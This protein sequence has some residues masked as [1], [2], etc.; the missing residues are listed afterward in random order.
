MNIKGAIFDFDGTLGDS[1]GYWE[2]QYNEISRIYCGGKKLILT[3]ED[4]KKFRTSLITDSMKLLHKNYNIAK[5]AEE[6]INYVNDSIKRFYLTEVKTKPGVVE[7]LEYLKNKNVKMCI[8]SATAEAEL[9]IAV[10]CC[11][12]ERYF[13]KLFSCSTLGFG[14]EKPDIF[15][16]ALD[17]LGTDINETLVIEDS[18]LA[19]E[20]AKKAGFKTVG[21]FDKN[22]PYTENQLA[23]YSDILV[24]EN[25]TLADLIEE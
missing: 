10:K 21:I 23:E 8:A 5:S 24:G 16:M 12:L 9:E 19:L 20:T 14:K 15:L 6:L 18:L 3:P 13:D 1:L 25:Q 4:D 22:N 17:Y 7:Y 2:W 11:G